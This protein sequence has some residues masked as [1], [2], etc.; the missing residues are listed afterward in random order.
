[1]IAVHRAGEIRP[2]EVERWTPPLNAEALRQFLTRVRNWEP[3]DWDAVFEDL[4]AVLDNHAPK[5]SEVEELAERLRGSLMRFVTIA[6]A[7]HADEKDENV[8][9]LIERAHSLPEA[10]PC[11]YWQAV[12]H[13]RQLGWVTNELL[14]RL[15][16]IK[17]I[18]AGA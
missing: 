10:L 1:M 7:G 13:L 9:V 11:D 2:R 14:E 16:A 6:L 3:L 15:S 18:R 5:A 4:A 17:H 12:G 8:Q